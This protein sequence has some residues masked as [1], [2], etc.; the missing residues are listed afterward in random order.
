MENIDKSKIYKEFLN[1]VN[2]TDYLPGYNE[3]AEEV[4][5]G[6]WDYFVQ[7][8]CNIREVKAGADKWLDCEISKIIITGYS[9]LYPGRAFDVPADPKDIT[10][11]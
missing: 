7:V 9:H 2:L 11:N 8:F 5:V 3:I 1:K 10:I 6:E 4:Q